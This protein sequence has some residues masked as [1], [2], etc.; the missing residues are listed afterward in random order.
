M[1]RLILAAA[2][3]GLSVISACQSGN[4]G[5][6]RRVAV[7][8]V[9]MANPFLWRAA[10]E[11]LETLPIESTDPVGG[12]I[13]Y[14]WKTFPEAPGERVRATVFILDSRLRADGVKVTVYR[15]V[16]ADGEWQDA[17]T[18]PE[19]AIQ[20]ENRILDRARLLRTSQIS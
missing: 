15:Q 9:G 10:L 12:V 17:L 5:A 18:D 4:N 20:I 1:K 3:T 7:E 6:D 2:L 16:S 8:S 11:T 13:S 19:T 14:D